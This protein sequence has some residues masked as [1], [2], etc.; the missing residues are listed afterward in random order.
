MVQKPVVSTKN[1]RPNSKN[2]HN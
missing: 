1:H 2:K